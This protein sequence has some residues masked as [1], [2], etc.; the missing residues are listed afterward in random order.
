MSYSIYEIKHR[1]KDRLK[2][3][4]TERELHIIQKRILKYYVG[5]SDLELLIKDDIQVHSFIA[6][7]VDSAITMLEYKIP[8]EYVI[9]MAEF[10]D[11]N[12]WVNDS[13]LI[14]RPET[15]EII[16]LV[17]KHYKSFPSIILDCGTGSGCIA[18]SLKK[19]FSESHVFA[20]DNSKAALVIAKMNA[21]S[22]K[23]LVNFLFYD[24][25]DDPKILPSN[26]DIFVSNPPYVLSSEIKDVDERVLYFEPHN[27]IFVPNDD[28]INMYKV[29]M[30]LY[31][32]ISSDNSIAIFEI[33]P[34]FANVVLD[35]A[36]DLFYGNKNCSLEKDFL[37]KER[38]LIIE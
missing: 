37:G 29:L 33:N 27:A 35:M 32:K 31:M 2:N 13:V 10:R 20:F 12:L 16:D 28:Y 21:I 11:L 3:I 5:L 23:T 22:N 30:D 18:I 25:F 4:Y 26:V 9:N 34:I 24:F 15:E 14:P 7:Q 17:K 1:I 38:F 8:L 19:L 36:R 6:K